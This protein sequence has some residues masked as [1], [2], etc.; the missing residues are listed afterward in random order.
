MATPNEDR[1]I[2]R[3]HNAYARAAARDLQENGVHWA[4]PSFRLTAVDWANEAKPVVILRNDSQVLAE[5]RW[6]GDRLRA[7]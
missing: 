2:Y 5:Y 1:L 6:T 3:A 4:A 7:I